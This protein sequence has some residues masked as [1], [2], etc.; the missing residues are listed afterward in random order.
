MLA[1]LLLAIVPAGDVVVDRV[2]LVELNHCYDDEGRHVFD[3][4]IWYDWSPTAE[5][6]QVVAWRL[7]KSPEQLPQRRWLLSPGPLSPGSSPSYTATW[8]DGDVLRRVAAAAYRETWTQFDPELAEREHLPQQWRKGLR[9]GVRD[10]GL[11]ARAADSL[12]RPQP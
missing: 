9:R 2:D 6:H 12:P 1:L 11:G 10:E 8:Q 3:Q 5:R 4:V 7:V